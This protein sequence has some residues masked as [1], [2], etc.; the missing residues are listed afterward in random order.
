MRTGRTA[1]VFSKKI[2]LG[3]S[4]VS[5]SSVFSLAAT[6]LAATSL[7]LQQHYRDQAIQYQETYARFMEEKSGNTGAMIFFGDEQEEEEE[8][9]DAYEL[10]VFSIDRPGTGELVGKSLPD[11]G[12]LMLFNI[13]FFCRIVYRLPALRCPLINRFNR[14]LVH[15]S[16]KN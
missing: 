11:M 9:I 5:P 7:D 13:V 4:R 15:F 12:L 6:N 1:S 14:C 3:I 10:P 2:A 16:K 8:P